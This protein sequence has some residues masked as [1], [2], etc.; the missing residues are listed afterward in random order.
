MKKLLILLAIFTTFAAMA[1]SAGI[2]AD[3]STANASAMLDVSSA[4]KGFL[5]PRMTTTERDLIASPAT[6]LV[7]FNTIT[8]GLEIK[9][10][11]G[12]ISLKASSDVVFLP[13][14]VIGTQQ[15]ME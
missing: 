4:T 14:I 5:P 2:N 1:Q 15:W 13:T 6:G 3:G 11:T 8:N 10:I 12:W 9:S 7:I